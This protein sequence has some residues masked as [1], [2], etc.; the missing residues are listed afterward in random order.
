MRSRYD[1]LDDYQINKSSSNVVHFSPT[2]IINTSVHYQLTDEQLNL[3]NR[4]PTYIPPCQ[5]YVSSSYTSIH[6]M[7]QKQ[8]KSLQHELNILFAK[9]DINSSQSMFLNQKIK[10]EFINIFFLTLPSSLYQRALYEKQLVDSIRQHLKVNHLILRRTADQRNVFYLGNQKEFDQ[11]A[12]EFMMK[13]VDIFEMTEIVDPNNLQQ[14][15]ENLNKMIRSM[16]SH[17]EKI[18]QHRKNIYKD[19]L[20]KLIITETKVQIPYLYFLPDLSKVKSSFF[21]LFIIQYIFKIVSI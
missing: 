5:M 7:I 19:L 21:C 6:D 12:N 13:A 10:D 17:M 18:F 11:K 20:G 16:N 2:V 3:L 14:T 15:Y 9:H 1:I 4:G 8:Y